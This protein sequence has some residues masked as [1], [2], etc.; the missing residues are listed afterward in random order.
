[1]SCD[2][3]FFEIVQNGSG[4]PDLHDDL[5]HSR[6]FELCVLCEQP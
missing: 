1:M 6:G 5:V 2:A 4:R 3:P